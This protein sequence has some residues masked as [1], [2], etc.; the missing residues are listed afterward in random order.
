MVI[1]KNINGESLN[2]V[3]SGRLDTTTAPELEASLKEDFD[4]VNKVEFD[5][6]E[7]EYVSS[8][9]LRV[10]LMSQKTMSAKNGSMVIKHVSD[11]VMEVFDMTGFSSFLTIED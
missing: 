10:L 7:I 11:E 9:G 4:K 3:L 5:F 1:N 2:V 8:A 6:Q